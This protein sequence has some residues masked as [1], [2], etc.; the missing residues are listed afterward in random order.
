MSLNGK[1]I[2]ITGA[3][4]G[5]GRALA[6]GFVADGANVVA[7]DLQE[8]SHDDPTHCLA[9]VGDV[10]SEADVDRVVAAAHQ[11]F[12]PIDVLVNNAGIANAGTLLARPFRAWAAVIQ[13]NLIG[14]ALCTHRVLPDMLARGSGRIINVVSRAAEFPFAGLSA[15]AASKAGV[16][17]FTRA[18]A[19][20]VGPPKQ[21]DILVNA[22]FPGLTNTAMAQGLDPSLLQEPEAVYPHTRFLVTLPAGG[23]HG[24]VFW[25]S[26]EYAMYAQ[27]NNPPPY[28]AVSQLPRAPRN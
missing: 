13:V 24:R 25:N 21:P 12:G 7:F 15:Y 18:L 6:C 2:L 1:V 19:A 4:R 10:T 28:K 5:I 20:E 22:L 26:Q 11:R 8:T 16:I 14:V 17:S 23:P 3:S 27:F 9:V